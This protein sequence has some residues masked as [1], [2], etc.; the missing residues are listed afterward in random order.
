MGSWATAGCRLVWDGLS[1]AVISAPR[2]FILW[3]VG[4]GL[5]TWLQPGSRE[6]QK[7]VRLETGMISLP[8]HSVG[9]GRS[10]G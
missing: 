10:Q 5:F 1:S 4:L 8:L 2:G 3:Q 6:M 9:P 7:P